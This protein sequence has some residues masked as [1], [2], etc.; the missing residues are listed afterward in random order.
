M[1]GEGKKEESVNNC[2]LGSW[3]V[4]R[5]A[6]LVFFYKFGVLRV[7]KEKRQHC[8]IVFLYDKQFLFFLLI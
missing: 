8:V 4:G 6:F 3:I 1:D 5:G 7:G 2:F